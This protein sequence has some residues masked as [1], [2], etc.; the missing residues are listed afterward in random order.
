MFI[1]ISA[2]AIT[3][4]GKSVTPIPQQIS[5]LQLWLDAADA[6]TLFQSA[7]GATAT[8]NNDPIGQWLD[9]S[10]NA[11]H[12]TQTTGAN[13]PLLAKASKNGLNTVF[14][15]G[16]ND[17]LVN[18]TQYDIGTNAFTMFAILQA[19]SP[20]GIAVWWEQRN[21]AGLHP[22]LALYYNPSGTN[23]NWYHNAIGPTVAGANN[24]YT[25][26][27]LQ[28]TGTNCSMATNANSYTTVSQPSIVA[29]GDSF[30]GVG[31]NNT[32]YWKGNV[33]EVLMYNSVLSAGNQTKIINYLNGK[34]GIY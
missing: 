15:D 8:A 16:S 1:G 25:I 2:G 12:S 22:R 32:Q 19:T 28:R 23:W 34:W 21:V 20:G 4:A 10:G 30:I 13:K 27:K 29:T 26:V 24:T 7:G 31:Y 14:F 33:A 3:N 17:Q 6:S 18:A 5:G 9:K 11:R